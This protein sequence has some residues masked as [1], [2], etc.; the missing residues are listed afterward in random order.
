MSWESSAD[1]RT[2]PCVKYLANGKLLDST[3]SSAPCSVMT[4]RN[5]MGSV[6]GRLNKEKIYVY[7]WLIHVVVQQKLTQPCGAIILQLKIIF[8]KKALAFLHFN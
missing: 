1:I 7:I 5:G 8:L 3:G 4:W 6:G 2:L